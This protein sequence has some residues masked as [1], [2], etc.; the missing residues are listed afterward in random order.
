MNIL[1]WE[2]ILGKF[3]PGDIRKISE[4]VRHKCS[5]SRAAL[6]T[7]IGVTIANYE[8]STQ[9]IY[10]YPWIQWNVTWEHLNLM[11]EEVQE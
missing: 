3:L 8:P 5:I 9:S 2:F 4:T 6:G 1:W 7:G 11:N 10:I